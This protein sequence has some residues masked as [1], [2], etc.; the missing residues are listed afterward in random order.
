MSIVRPAGILPFSFFWDMVH[1]RPTDRWLES[2]GMAMP[3]V[4]SPVI[5]DAG[6]GYVE[7]SVVV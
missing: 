1:L 6:S 5:S 4:I 3:V 2:C 7:M